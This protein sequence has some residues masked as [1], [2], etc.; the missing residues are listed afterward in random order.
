MSIIRQRFVLPRIGIGRI[1]YESMLGFLHSHS[2]IQNTRHGMQV[3]QRNI[4]LFRQPAHCIGKVKMGIFNLSIFIEAASLG[5]SYQYGVHSTGTGFINK[6]FQTCH[7]RIEGT[8]AGTFLLLIVVSEFH[9]DII[10][11]F[12][13]RQGF[14][15]TSGSNESIGRLS[16]FGIVG[17]ANAIGKETGNHLSPTG[18]GFIILIH[19]S[20]VTA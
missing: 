16:G 4:F 1:V 6:G 20:G 2:L 9:E 5:R 13:L 10:S 7:K 18:P 14:L 19:Y 8:F 3:Y 17:K 11:R 12:H 15:Q